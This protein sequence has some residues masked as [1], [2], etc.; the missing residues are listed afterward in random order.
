MSKEITYRDCNLDDVKEAIRKGALPYVC[1]HTNDDGRA[2]WKC[3]SH[4]FMKQVSGDGSVIETSYYYS[5]DADE[6]D[7]IETYIMCDY[8]GGFHV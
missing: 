8:E 5:H 1:I 4:L 6:R 2:T 3:G 7:R